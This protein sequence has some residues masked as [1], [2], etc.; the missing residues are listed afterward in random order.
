MIE[1]APSRGT[2]HATLLAF[3]F[4]KFGGVAR[5]AAPFGGGAMALT[6][7]HDGLPLPPPAICI[8]QIPHFP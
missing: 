3:L 4:W 8:F 1:A 7:L 5:R 2:R 6:G